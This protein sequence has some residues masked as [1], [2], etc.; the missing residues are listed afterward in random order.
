LLLDQT[1]R[2]SRTFWTL[3]F[4]RDVAKP[5][6]GGLQRAVEARGGLTKLRCLLARRDTEVMVEV[7]LSERIDGPAVWRYRLAF[8]SEGKGAQR[9]IVSQEVVEDFSAGGRLLLNR[10]DK[11]DQGLPRNR[12]ILFLTDLPAFG[13]PAAQARRTWRSWPTR[14]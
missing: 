6:G 5:K 7:E 14:R 1:H 4:L 8:K 12:T 2:A 9:V 10:P 13:P 3:R 11:D